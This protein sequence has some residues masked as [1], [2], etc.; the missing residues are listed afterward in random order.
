LKARVLRTGDLRSK[1]NKNSA[2]TKPSSKWLNLPN[3]GRVATFDS[4]SG[5][6]WIT[7]KETD[8]YTTER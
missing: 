1:A 4:D 8:L 2:V 5:R 6:T 7:I 3:T